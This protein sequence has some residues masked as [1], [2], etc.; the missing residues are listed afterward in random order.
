M[1]DSLL[2]L[3]TKRA[4]N[5]MRQPSFSKSIGCPHSVLDCQPNEN[6]A[7]RRCLGLPYLPP[8]GKGYGPSEEGVIGRLARIDA[9]LRKAPSVTVRSVILKLYTVDE[10]PKLQIFH[11]HLYRQEKPCRLHRCYHKRPLR[12]DAVVIATR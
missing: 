11:K 5:R 9:M 4:C 6:F 8:R 7:I 12:R 2:G 10:V 1:L 3:I